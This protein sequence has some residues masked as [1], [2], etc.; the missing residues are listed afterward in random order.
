M[1][2]LDPAPIL[3]V[4]GGLAGAVRTPNL[5][6]IAYP[7]YY[8]LINAATAFALHRRRAS[9]GRAPTRT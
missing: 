4:L 2:D 5:S 7:V 1:T 9:L 3:G 6:K 8:C